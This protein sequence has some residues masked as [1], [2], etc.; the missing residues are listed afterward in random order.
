MV[1][2]SLVKVDQILNNFFFKIKNLKKFFFSKYFIKINL[3]VRHLSYKFNEEF[4]YL[5]KDIDQ[6]QPRLRIIFDAILFP[7]YKCKD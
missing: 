6:S 7:S 1:L 2:V 5:T 4:N 3:D